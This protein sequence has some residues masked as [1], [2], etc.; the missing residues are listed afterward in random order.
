MDD[1]GFV[2]ERTKLLLHLVVLLDQGV[3]ELVGLLRTASLE[4][5]LLDFLA[6]VMKLIG[7]GVDLLDMIA[8][9]GGR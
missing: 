4:A 7:N 5:E 2:A 9:F 6:K 8:F 3:E 1:G